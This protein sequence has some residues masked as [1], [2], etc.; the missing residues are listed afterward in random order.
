MV[1]ILSSSLK[2]SFDAALEET[3]K[4]DLTI[5]TT[6]FTA[7][8][9]EVASLV[10]TVPEAAAVSEFRQNVFRYDGNNSFL[11]AVDP[12]T[13]ESVATLEMIEGTTAA[14]SQGSILVHADVAEANGFAQGDTV[15]L[16][17]PSTGQRE[18][19]V[20]GIY[21]ENRLVGDWVVS[22]QTYEQNYTEQ[23]DS[24]VLVKG[25]PGVSPDDLRAAVE[26]RVGDFP[27]I[28]VQDQAAFREK[29]AGLV[30]QLLGLVTAMLLLAVLIALFGIVNTLSLSIFERTREIGLLRAVGMTRRQIRA[31]VRWES[32]IIAVF[33][34]LL[35][36]AIGVFFGFSLQRA[37]QEEGLSE[38]A[39][40]GRQLAVYVVLA[41]LAGVVA[42]VAP[43]RKAAQLNVLEAITYE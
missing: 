10:R 33:G 27:N 24:F 21:G 19:V 1:T 25:A 30:D 32:V 34:A 13:I 16:A 26:A 41:G 7:F 29:Q 42:A 3:L 14:L 35:G 31:M 23:L 9:P 15:T 43:A 8:S 20:G 38:L 18:F 40:P 37:L 2:A 4:A 39:I 12:A 11:T 28:E 36:L 5:T 17:F 22:V 6:S